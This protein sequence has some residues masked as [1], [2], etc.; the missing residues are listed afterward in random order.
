LFA[1]AQQPAVDRIYPGKGSLTGWLKQTAPLSADSPGPAFGGPTFGPVRSRSQIVIVPG[2]QDRLIIYRNYSIETV[3]LNR[4]GSMGPAL[5]RVPMK[6]YSTPL[7]T[8]VIPAGSRYLPEIGAGG[9]VVMRE[10]ADLRLGRTIPLAGTGSFASGRVRKVWPLKVV[11]EDVYP[12]IT[13]D[14]DGTIRDVQLWLD[15]RNPLHPHFVQNWDQVVGHST[16]GCVHIHEFE[17]EPQPFG[18]ETLVENRVQ[19]VENRVQVIVFDL[20][21]IRTYTGTYAYS[22]VRYTDVYYTSKWNPV[23]SSELPGYRLPACPAGTTYELAGAFHSDASV[24]DIFLLIRRPNM[25]ADLCATTRI[26]NGA[27]RQM[28]CIEKGCRTASV[29]PSHGRVKLLISRTIRSGREPERLEFQTW[30]R[31]ADGYWAIDS[32]RLPKEGAEAKPFP[33]FRLG[34]KFSQKSIGLSGEAIGITAALPTVADVNGHRTVIPTKE[35]LRAVADNTGTVWIVLPMQDR[36]S[37]PELQIASHRFA[38]NLELRPND[39]LG[40]YLS[41]LNGSDLTAKTGRGTALLANPTLANDVASAVRS[42]A[43]AAPKPSA[44]TGTAPDGVRITADLPYQWLGGTQPAAPGRRRL[45][46]EAPRAWTFDRAGAYRSVSSAEAQ[47]HITQDINTLVLARPGQTHT[48][49]RAAL[50]DDISDGVNWIGGRLSDAASTVSKGVASVVTIVMDG[51]EV[52][53]KVVISELHYVYVGIIDTIHKAVDAI[54][55]VLDSAGV[56]LGEVANW[57]PDKLGFLF[58]WKAIKEKRDELRDFVRSNLNVVE[59]WLPNPTNAANSVVSELSSLQANLNSYRSLSGNATPLSSRFSLLGGLP[60]LSAV[61]GGA[62]LPKLDWLFSKMNAALSD[63]RR[64]RRAADTRHASRHRRV[65]PA[66]CRADGISAR[67][68]RQLGSRGRGLDQ[69]HRLVRRSHGDG[70]R[71]HPARQGQSADRDRSKAH[72]QG[73]PSHRAS[74]SKPGG[75]PRL[76]RCK[77]PNSVLRRLLPRPYWAGFELFRCGLPRGGNFCTAR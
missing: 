55:C 20:P 7:V 1:V 5:M 3:Y 28:L 48:T 33:A 35:P 37:F 38:Q 6:P 39:R 64:L 12:C 18:H 71:R 72:R 23:I 66:D 61:G 65:A 56:A 41:S 47:N 27:W 73:G 21:Q 11:R 53:I 32:A 42:I 70:A 30:E 76:A 25:T 14:D 74:A 45:G 31:N 67:P 46:T 16:N 49:S 9:A 58:D 24:M 2:D 8:G 62:G 10:V 60:S 68:P 43:A 57:L 51:A 40:N 59:Q 63:L 29:F 44:A 69:Q 54:S 77:A 52:A 36:L 17:G 34:L 75:G 4:D 50:L 13:L 15:D 26:A 22:T 19:V